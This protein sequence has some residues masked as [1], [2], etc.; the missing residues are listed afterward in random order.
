MTASSR[1]SSAPTCQRPA[2]QHAEGL[3]VAIAMG[4]ALE[5][6]GQQME[7]R[8]LYEAALRDGRA[9]NPSEAAQLVRL[10]A[11]TYLQEPAIDEARDCA[12]VALAIAEAAGDEAARGHA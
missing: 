9:T 2:V 5:R 7:A 12:A 10:V 3:A 4:Q 11:R 8:T 1:A 6:D